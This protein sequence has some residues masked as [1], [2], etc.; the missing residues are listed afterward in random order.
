[1][2]YS[3]TEFEATYRRCFP[4][5]MLCNSLYKFDFLTTTMGN[6]KASNRGN[7]QQVQFSRIFFYT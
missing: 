6:A 5:A 7:E 1:M 3:I 4:P 2:Q